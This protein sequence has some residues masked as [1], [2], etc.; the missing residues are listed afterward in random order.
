MQLLTLLPNSKPLCASLDGE[1]KIKGIE[2]YGIKRAD[3]SSIFPFELNFGFS[4][5]DGAATLVGLTSRVT[6]YD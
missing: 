2:V 4:A 3:E 5:R 1:F 6:H